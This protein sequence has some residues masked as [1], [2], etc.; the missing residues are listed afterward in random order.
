M[1]SMA[2]VSISGADRFDFFKFSFDET[3]KISRF[4]CVN[5][6]VWICLLISILVVLELFSFC[7]LGNRSLVAI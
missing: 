6:S 5:G 4:L 3:V 1:V 7:N 2:L